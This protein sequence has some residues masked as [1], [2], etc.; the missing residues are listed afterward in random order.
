MDRPISYSGSVPLVEDFLNANRYAMT[1][2]GLLALDLLGTS[3]LVTGMACTPTAPASLSVNI[4]PGRIYSLQNVDNN[5]YSVL[6]ADTTHSIL[7]QGILPDVFPVTVSAPNTFSFSQNWLVQVGYQDS[8]TG[9][10]LLAYFNSQNPQIP[11][12]GANGNGA[13]QPTIRKGLAVV[14]IKPGTAAVTGTQTT[15]GADAGN[16]GLYVITV[17]NGQTAITAGN[18]AQLAT[19]PFLS[20]NGAIHGSQRFTANGTFIVPPGVTNIRVSGC[21][22]GGGG[23]G[24]AG[25]N[26]AANSAGGGAGGAAGLAT[27]QQPF[28]VAPAQSL[29]VVIGAAG[30]GGAGGAAGAG[31]ASG[32]NGGTTSV[33]ALLS[34]PG[35]GGAGAGTFASGAG[36]GG[37]GGGGT[38]GA[39]T[40]SSG[41]DGQ[42][43]AGGGS[44]ASGPFGGG[45]GGGRGTL[46]GTAFGGGPAGGNGAGGGG[47]GACYGAATAA[48][49]LGTAGTAGFVLIEW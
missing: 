8:D 5:T 45:G 27:I 30:A 28:T 1:G 9:I 48:G 4:A 19:A 37:G 43:G 13:A 32:S 15:P 35:G 33:G 14:T 25:N 18:I 6:P 47:G 12:S 7:K 29:A 24:G 23:G 46:S 34:L 26:G 22:G 16:V 20:P 21:G 10:S 40:G 44:G 11:L 49:G 38:A 17:A 39:A 3:N 42:A 31:G 2:L 36:G 41:T